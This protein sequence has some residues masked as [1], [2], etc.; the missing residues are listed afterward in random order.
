MDKDRSGEVHFGE[1][2]LVRTASFLFANCG[3]LTMNGVGNSNFGVQEVPSTL[4]VES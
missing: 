2:E 3:S 4:F 1:Q